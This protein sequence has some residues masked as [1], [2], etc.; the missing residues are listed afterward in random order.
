MKLDERLRS[1]ERARE[2]KEK[3]MV[4]LLDAMSTTKEKIKYLY[5]TRTRTTGLQKY[6][7]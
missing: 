1:Y 2:T 4:W 6:C 3:K 5:R 7:T